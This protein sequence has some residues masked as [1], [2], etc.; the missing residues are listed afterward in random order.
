MFVCYVTYMKLLLW[1]AN[2]VTL[3]WPDEDLS[4]LG[5]FLQNLRV[6]LRQLG[7]HFKLLRIWSTSEKLKPPTMAQLWEVVSDH[8]PEMAVCDSVHIRNCDF[9]HP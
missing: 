7:E 9:L 3:D 6:R 5:S 8:L 2:K 4:F 1:R